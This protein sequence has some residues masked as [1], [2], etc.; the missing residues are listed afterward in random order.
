MQWRRYVRGIGARASSSFENSVYSAAAAS[1]TV[2]ILKNKNV[3]YIFV[4][5]PRNMLK[6][7]RNPKEM[8]GWEEEE[9]L[10]CAPPH[11]T[12]WRRH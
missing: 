9:N 5:F 1:L 2:R 10:C 4:Y 3:Y 12:S 7:S 11:L 6:Q 8:P